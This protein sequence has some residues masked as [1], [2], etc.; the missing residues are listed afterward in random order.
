MLMGAP[1]EIHHAH[2]VT[3]D[4]RLIEIYT[5]SG[6]LFA[7]HANLVLIPDYDITMA[8]LTAGPEAS[9][10]AVQ[11]L[12]AAAIR[13]LLPAIEKAGKGQAESNYAGVF[14]DK[15]TNS[16]LNFS[17]DA[18]PGLKVSNF[19]V[20]GVDIAANYAR[21]SPSSGKPGPP[22]RV[23]LY[24]TISV[25]GP[26]SGPKQAAWRA[27][28]DAPFDAAAAAQ[29]DAIFPWP[30]STCVAWAMADRAAYGLKVWI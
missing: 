27:S 14:V 2:N 12:T 4:G 29:T 10:D 25:A 20:R 24:P 1:W 28:F 18:A 16:T 7:Y 11:A 23:R 17:L 26:G 30:D 9:P 8:V 13:T 6:D 15:K 5:K 21:L 22:A 3:V 19:S